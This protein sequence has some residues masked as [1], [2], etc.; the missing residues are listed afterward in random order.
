[1]STRRDTRCSPSRIMSGMRMPLILEKMST[2]AMPVCLWEG[3]QKLSGPGLLWVHPSSSHS[4]TPAHVLG[5]P[6]C[7]I[8]SPRRARSPGFLK[9]TQPSRPINL[10]FSWSYDVACFSHLQA[11]CLPAAL[12][13][14]YPVS[15]Q[16]LHLL[17]TPHSHCRLP[18]EPFIKPGLTVF[19]PAKA[20][21]WPLVYLPSTA[22]LC[23]PLTSSSPGP[24][25]ALLPQSQSCKFCGEHQGGQ[26]R[27]GQNEG[28]GSRG[29]RVAP[30]TLT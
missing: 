1:M 16:R 6:R 3:R 21:L 20:R 2:S 12:L 4:S 13:P 5:K 17:T 7:F 8:W 19:S 26:R 11:F 23:T 14:T 28:L 30:A 24:H 18:S 27:D 15:D 9:S 29:V 22:L 10:H 25:P